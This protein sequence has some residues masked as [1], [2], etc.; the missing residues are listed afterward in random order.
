MDIMRVTIQLPDDMQ[1][2]SGNGDDVPR[3]SLEAIAV[4]AYRSSA[5]TDDGQ[6]LMQRL[7]GGG[8]RQVVEHCL[9]DRM[10]PR[11]EECAS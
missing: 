8:C 4:G 11:R 3:R 2:L 7:A 6:L 5:V 9:V 1:P 10:Q